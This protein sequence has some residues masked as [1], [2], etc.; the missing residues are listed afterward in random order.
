M[1]DPFLNI[2]HLRLENFI[3]GKIVPTRREL[4]NLPIF[5]MIYS[6]QCGHC[7]K[8]KPDFLAFANQMNR[9]GKVVVAAIANNGLPDE[10]EQKGVLEMMKGVLAQN[11]ISFQGFPTFILYHRGKY[12]EYD[13][14]R[15]TQGYLEFI[16]GKTGLAQ[17]R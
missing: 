1:S 14:P 2:P 3:Q 13:G 6:N 11:G 5:I 15:S 8:A 7:L 12:I 9:S 10:P 16:Q 17:R 4:Q